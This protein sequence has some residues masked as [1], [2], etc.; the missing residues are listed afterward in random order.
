MFKTFIFHERDSKKFWRVSV[1]GAA[2]TVVY[3]R[4]GSACCW[5]IQGV[6][7]TD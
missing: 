4:I 5:E 2:L 6:G 3:G 1:E 7:F